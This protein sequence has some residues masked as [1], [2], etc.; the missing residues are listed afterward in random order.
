MISA[1][2][3]RII[4]AL[5]FPSI[6]K[7]RSL[8]SQL[9]PKLCRLK[10]GM[11]MFT[12]FG[13]AF[14]EE[15]IAKGFSIF[16]D[17]KYHDIPQTVAGA[18]R[19]AAELGVWMVNV[20]IQGGVRMLSAAV[21]EIAK[22]PKDERPLLIGVT[23]LTSLENSDLKSMG[24]QEEISTLVLRMARLAQDLGLDGVVC[25]AQ[26]AKLIRENVKDNFLLVTPG[27]RIDNDASDQRRIATPEFALQMGA[28]YLVIG[29]PITEAE[30][31]MTVLNKINEKIL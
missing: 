27:I 13:P 24:L 5:D 31:P 4:I 30:N 14:V 9:N 26:E 18:C 16:L 21:N 6:D 2:D 25:S 17:L 1:I 3:P 20:H 22:F 23:L 29:R 8:V 28:D 11:T 12:L 19:A 10:V 15:L 7:A